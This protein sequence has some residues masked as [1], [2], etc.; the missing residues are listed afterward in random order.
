MTRELKHTIIIGIAMVII[1]QLNSFSVYSQQSQKST[2]DVQQHI[3]EMKKM[4]GT[5]ASAD[6]I[7]NPYAHNSAATDSGRI[8]YQHI[9]SVCH[10]SSGKGDGIA[11]SGLNVKP[12]DHTSAFVQQ[13]KDGALFWE[14]SNGHAPM[15]AYKSVISVKQRWALINYI[16]TLDKSKTTSH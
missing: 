9:C 11:A 8:V 10:G 14:I 12:A 7:K 13:Q 16:R 2:S 6:T 1:F 3:A 5:P 4:W 15:P